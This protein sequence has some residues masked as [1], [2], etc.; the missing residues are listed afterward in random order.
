MQ[1]VTNCI[2]LSNDKVLLLQKPRRG[3]WVAPGG[4]MELEE[5]VK[6]SVVREYR[7]E[8][9]IYLKNPNLKGVFTFIMKDKE[10]DKIVSEWMMFSFLATEYDGKNVQQSEEG[11]IEWHDVEAVSELPMAP[12]DYHILDYLINGTGMIY[13]TFT[14]TSDF[15]LLSYRLDPN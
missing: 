11:K 8:T 13:G 4:K 2:L 1:R 14:Y 5:S 7:E 12:G 10:E 6:D 3:W 9:G 15:E